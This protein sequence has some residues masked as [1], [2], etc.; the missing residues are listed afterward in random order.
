MP[1][2]QLTKTLAQ[3]AGAF[4]AA[5]LDDLGRETGFL[6][7]KHDITPAN[8]IPCLVAALGSGKVSTLTELCFWFNE[9]TGQDVAEKAFWDRLANAGFTVLMDKFVERISGLLILQSLRFLPGSPFSRFKR[10]LA[11]NGSSLAVHKAQAEAFPGRF[12][13]TSPAAVEL[14][15]T[16]DLLNEA[17]EVTYMTPDKDSERDYLPEPATL[18]GCLL[19]ADRGYPSWPYVAKV[20]DA[21][22]AYIMRLKGGLK[23]DVVG[24]FQNGLLVQVDLDEVV[25]L[26]AYCK[27]HDDDVLDLLVRPR[28]DFGTFRLTIL[29]TPK[30]RTFLVNNLPASDFPAT[31]VGLA[32]RLRWQVELI[33]KDWKSYANLHRFPTANEQITVGLMWAS[34]ATALLKRFM[35]KAAQMVGKVAVSTLKAARI[36]PAILPQLIT[37]MLE[38]IDALEEAFVHAIQALMSRAKRSN[39]KRE[40]RIGRQQLGPR[41]VYAS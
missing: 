18:A 23:P 7:R 14:H 37:A 32:Y 11:Q 4:E 5:A 39:T 22:G 24:I 38:G 13:A 12:T 26:Q 41:P 20:R 40:R 15:A 36:L 9:M 8:L 33:F 19:L 21:D 16:H 3:V 30:G 6:R 1:K 10:I 27:A 34:I 31:F 2:L 17:P 28:G 25:D 29:K 35:A